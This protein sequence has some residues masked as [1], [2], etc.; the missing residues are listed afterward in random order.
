MNL[1][2]MEV[3]EHGD[4]QFCNQ[5]FSVISG[6]ELDEIKGENA[7]TMPFWDSAWNPLFNQNENDQVQDPY[8]A[9]VLAENKRGAKE[10]VEALLIAD[11]TFSE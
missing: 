8:G 7:A 9:E 3:D 2:L 5:S 1:G 10:V 4:V 6:F 11:Q